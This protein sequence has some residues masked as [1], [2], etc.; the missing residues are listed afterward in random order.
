MPRVIP[1]RHKFSNE[2]IVVCHDT[3]TADGL[4]GLGVVK[5]GEKLRADNPIVQA[6]PLRFVDASL[7]EN[8]WPLREYAEPPADHD[9]LIEIPPQIPFEERVRARWDLTVDAGYGYGT[10]IARGQILSRNERLVRESPHAFET[11][12]RP[13]TPA[14]FEDAA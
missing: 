9:P 7:P 10:H 11:I 5:R 6:H 4:P 14:D 13:L 8:E 1:R 12:P 3:F 2:Q